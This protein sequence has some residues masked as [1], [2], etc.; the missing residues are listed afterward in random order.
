MEPRGRIRCRGSIV[1]AVTNAALADRDQ[2]PLRDLSIGAAG[3]VGRR[4]DGRFGFIAIRQTVALETDAGHE[5]DARALVAKAE[6]E[7][8]VTVSL[9]VPVET[10]VEVHAHARATR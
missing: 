8:L 10:T 7:C 3:I 9:D 6:D 2:L 4:H 5:H 1:L